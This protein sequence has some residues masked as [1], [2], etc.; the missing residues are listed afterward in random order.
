MTHARA[1][2]LAALLAVALLLATAAALAI[3]NHHL[4]RSGAS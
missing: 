2:L 1:I 4:T 3:G